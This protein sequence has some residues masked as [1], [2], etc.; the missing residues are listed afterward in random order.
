MSTVTVTTTTDSPDVADRISR[1]A[2]EARLAACGKVS[3]PVTSTYRWQGQVET[4]TE[5]LVLFITTEAKT[6]PLIEHIT[7]LHPYDVPE[8]VVTP[9]IGGSPAYLDW[10]AAQTLSADPFG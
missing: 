1:T 8:V 5:W 6:G 4:A 10:V 9:V 7:A 3:G 2:V